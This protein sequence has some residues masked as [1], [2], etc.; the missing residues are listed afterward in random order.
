[1]CMFSMSLWAM[2]AAT[3]AITSKNSN[4]ILVARVLNC[5]FMLNVQV[6]TDINDPNF[7]IFMFLAV[8]ASLMDL[9]DSSR[10]YRKLTVPERELCRPLG[11]N[12]SEEVS[13]EPIDPVF[14][15]NQAS[16]SGCNLIRSQ[17]CMSLNDL[18]GYC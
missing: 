13:A 2:V 1:M 11:Q 10:W 6:I 8:Q 9:R 5:E 12:L 3:I 14:R 16:I 15:R 4:Q 7:D 17:Y 18:E